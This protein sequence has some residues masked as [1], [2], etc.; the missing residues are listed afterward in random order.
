MHVPLV[1]EHVLVASVGIPVGMMTSN[2]VRAGLKV[3]P[4]VKGVD[5]VIVIWEKSKSVILSSLL[6][7]VPVIMSYVYVNV[8]KD[9]SFM[10]SSLVYTVTS[11]LIAVYATS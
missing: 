4:K 3:D 8:V 10:K 11:K 5:K 9:F 2:I 1:T 7:V 6:T